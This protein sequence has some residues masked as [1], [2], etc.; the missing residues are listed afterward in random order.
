MT[1]AVPTPVDTDPGEVVEISAVAT[2]RFG[3]FIV[4]AGHTPFVTD[5][6]TSS[7]GPG[8]AVQ[9]GQLLLASL[10]SCGLGL[11]QA[12]AA[13]LGIALRE[14]G[15]RVSF[16]RDPH[17]KTRYRYIRLEFTLPGATPEQAGTLVEHFTQSCP[18][19]NTLKRG[20][21]IE[22]LVVQA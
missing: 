16:Q 8:E 19:Y 22:A 12:R 14:P 21:E 15:A 7:G 4:S 11:V 2:Q 10:A 3:R 13:E 18:I 6:R 1:A 5:S 9:A 20:G 17:D